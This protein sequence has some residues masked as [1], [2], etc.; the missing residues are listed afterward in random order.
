ME[1]LKKRKKLTTGALITTFGLIMLVRT[2]LDF[3]RRIQLLPSEPIIIN[4]DET[5]VWMVGHA[6]V[7]INFF[8][9]VILTDPL[10]VRGLP[11]PK[12]R[13]MHGYKA[14]ELPELDY[15]I[16]SHA[17]LDHFDKRTL[18]K[19]ADKTKTLIVPR[20]CRDLVE[21]MPFQKII[22]LDWDKTNLETDLN[23]F[24]YKAKHW[25]KRF[26][27]ESAD[28]GY[29]CYVLE[30]NNHAIFFGG[31]TAYGEYFKDI[32]NKHKIDI[33]LLPISAYKPMMLTS[34]HMNP[35]EAHQAFTDLKS[36]HCIPIHWGSFRL[37]LEAMGEPPRLF[38]TRAEQNGVTE[39]THILPNGKSFGLEIFK[40][41][42]IDTFIPE[43]TPESIKIK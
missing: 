17:H 22:E 25:G 7:L 31:D 24:A 1:L 28:R 42:I 32:G 12:R 20:A 10:L 40:K 13:V 5:R 4:P 14:N 39:R 41:E 3:F 19:L 38:K 11:I 37:A 36:A 21:K 30:R 15:V 33:A 8:G 34:H 29:N 26:P 6:T 9:T 43:F 18:R 2:I 35:L 16:I 23:I 27:W